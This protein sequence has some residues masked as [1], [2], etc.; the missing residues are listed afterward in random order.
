MTAAPHPTSPESVTPTRTLTLFMSFSTT[1][2]HWNKSGML[3]RELE[4]YFHLLRRGHL[5]R[6]QIFSYGRRDFALLR[7]SGIAPDLIDRIE[8]LA[9]PA[10]L[11][12]LPL[13]NLIYSGIGPGLH[14]ASM[15]RSWWLKTNQISG[16][17][18]AVVAGKLARRPLLVR[19]GYLLSNRHKSVKKKLAATVS[20]RLERM[21]FK[22]ATAITVPSR[23]DIDSIRPVVEAPQKIVFSPTFV[24]FGRFRP[25]E[26]LDFALPMVFVG[27]LEEVKNLPALV[28]AV[29]EVGHPLHIYGEGSLRPQ[30]AELIR[31]SGA[32]V[33][34]M[35]Q[36][37][38]DQ[39]G[40]V[41][42]QHSVFVLCS[43]HEGL[44]K[45]LLEAMAAGL[46]CACTIKGSVGELIEDGVTGYVVAST[47]A[48]DIA[49]TLRRA[50]TEER[51]DLGKAAA[52]K[53]AS[54]Y[55]LD[56]Y[57]ARELSILE[58]VEPASV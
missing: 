33:V 46:V 7:D 41:L 25:A 51:V 49:D 56:A 26:R 53:V 36:V 11:A 32:P 21:A 38:N 15:R 5:D 58:S 54:L 9:P 48:S 3:G 17:W 4:L 14:L 30:L 16:S 45:A 57:I 44:P 10:W 37:S 47:D 34:L 31:E 50:L 13:G 29:A 12:R 55:S 6:L 20:Q 18:A 19:F 40:E 42:Q 28:R 43:H 27:R 8:V 24:N 39:L 22:A 35:G 2:G 52:E 23:V 1:L